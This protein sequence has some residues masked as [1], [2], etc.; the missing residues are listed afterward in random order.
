MGSKIALGLGFC[1]VLITGAWETFS[2]LKGCADIHD[3]VLKG[4]FLELGG[5]ILPPKENTF[6]VPMCKKPTNMMKFDDGIFLESC[7]SNQEII[8][9]HPKCFPSE[10]GYNEFIHKNTSPFSPHRSKQHNTSW[11]PVSGGEKSLRWRHAVLLWRS[12]DEVGA[13]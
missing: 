3:G 6:I 11:T 9:M 7:E 2:R 5:R 1:K 8:G 10:S 13:E 12:S 4:R